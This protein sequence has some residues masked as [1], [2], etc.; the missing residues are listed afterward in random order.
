MN[1]SYHIKPQSE[2]QINRG[3]RKKKHSEFKRRNNNI[4]NQSHTQISDIFIKAYTRCFIVFSKW[5]SSP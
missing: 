1:V 4:N 3:R 2:T 5:P